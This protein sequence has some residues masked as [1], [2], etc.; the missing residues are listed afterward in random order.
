MS[1]GR[2]SMAGRSTSPAP[3]SGTPL[4]SGASPGRVGG[5]GTRRLSFALFF[6]TVSGGISGEPSTGFG[7]LCEALVWPLCA[8]V[9]EAIAACFMRNKSRR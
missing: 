6:M 7:P 4:K 2:V 3:V 8:A 1:C 9:K 5:A